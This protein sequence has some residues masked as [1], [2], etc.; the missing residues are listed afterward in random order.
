MVIGYNVVIEANNLTF[1]EIEMTNR[2][3]NNLLKQAHNAV[4]IMQLAKVITQDEAIEFIQQI[5]WVRT[6]NEAEQIVIDFRAMANNKGIMKMT[7][8]KL[9]KHLVKNGWREVLPDNIETNPVEKMG[10]VFYQKPSGKFDR[11]F[12]TSI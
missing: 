10:W 4:W 8:A 7:P 9:K 1:R 2:K 6:Q 12:V 11:L 3:F 5:G